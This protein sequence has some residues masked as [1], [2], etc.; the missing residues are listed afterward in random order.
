VDADAFVVALINEYRPGVPFGWHRD[1]PQ[2]DIVAGI[3]FALGMPNEVPTLP[4]S[5]IPGAAVLASIG[6]PRDCARAAFRVPHDARVA[7]G[8]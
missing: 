1:A 2:D 4:F 8:V 6:H 3:S 5:I 7:D